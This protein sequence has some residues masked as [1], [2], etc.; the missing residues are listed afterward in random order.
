MDKKTR[1]IAF[2]LPQF[3]PIP[4]NDTWWGKGFTEWTNVG[5]AKPL[6][7]GHYQPRVPADLG[8]YD[9]RMTEIRELQA[10][11]AFDAGIEGF[12]YWHYWFGDGKR[13]L[14]GPFNDVLNSGKPDYPFCLCW[15]NHSWF[16]KLWNPDEKKDTL[17]LE[18]K[19][20]GIDDY[21]NHFNT[22]LPA[23]KDKR[24][25]LVDNKPVF[26][27]YNLRSI[28][29][30]TEFIQ[31]W[32]TLAMEN[33]FDGF[34]FFSFE[35][36]QKDISKCLELGVNAVVFDSMIEALIKTTSGRLNYLVFSKLLGLPQ[37][38]GYKRYAKR[39]LKHLPISKEVIPCVVPNWDHTPRSGRKG[40]ILSNCSPK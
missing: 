8:Y 37:M 33:G 35:H 32:N 5:K 13:I 15:A 29:N 25:I 28:P 18:Q 34:Y 31:T 26:G 2:Y 17:L 7:P 22:I 27:L 11:M 38:V 36:K 39:L 19:Y 12:C 1:V 30:P 40:M 9:L 20:L 6:F 10:K 4:E 14:E 21:I 16:K 3:H 23:L 24:Y